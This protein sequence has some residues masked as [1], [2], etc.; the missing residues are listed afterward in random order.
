MIKLDTSNG[1]ALLQNPMPNRGPPI[2]FVHGFN[3]SS[4][5]WL[6]TENEEGF[7]S[8]AA[9]DGFDP[10]LLDLSDPTL[11]DIRKLA[12]EDL[13]E[14][15]RMVYQEKKCLLKL[16]LHILQYGI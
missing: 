2:L 10:W 8:I 3:S 4:E 13:H 11:A 14:A 9:N 16:E 15:I 7:A 12:T 5:I 6:D 1:T